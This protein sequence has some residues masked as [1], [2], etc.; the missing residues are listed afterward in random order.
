MAACGGDKRKP[1][2]K[3]AAATMQELVENISEAARK[4][5]PGFLIVPQ[6]GIE[7][8]Y[9][10]ADPKKPLDQ[11]YLEAIDAFG[12]EELFYYEKLAID[13]TRLKALRQLADEKKVLVSDFVSNRRQ[14]DD[15]IKR[16]LAEGFVPFVRMKNNYHYHEIPETITGESGRDITRMRQVRNYLYLMNLEDFD[17]PDDVVKAVSQ[18]NY[19]LVVLDLYFDKLQ[20]FSRKQIAAMKHKA[21]GG[22]RLVMC[23][24]N[25]GAAENW[26]YYWKNDWKPGHPDFLRRPYQGYKDETWVAFWSPEWQQ[27]LY[28]GKD[29]YLSRIL[30]AGFDGTY[31]DNTEA[32]FEVFKKSK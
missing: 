6:N 13:S 28:Q 20:P 22:K 4:R 5:H 27:L 24:L 16:N 3:S 32:Y 10:G 31:L 29:S 1:A 21:D 7:L 12:V 15:A 23:Y 26:R 9:A 30:E 14:A 18:T 19:D 8:A 25:I 11:K 17:T 2:K